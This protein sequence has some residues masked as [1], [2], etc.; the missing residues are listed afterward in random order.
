MGLTWASHEE[1]QW[2]SGPHTS[3]VTCGKENC[4]R[5]NL[6]RPIV[7]TSILPHHSKFHL[8]SISAPE[9]CSDDEKSI[10]I[11]HIQ[12]LEDNQ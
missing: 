7:R 10:M 9:I 12:L 11:F 1:T 3:F 2:Q 8:Q 5:P 4:P 6:Q